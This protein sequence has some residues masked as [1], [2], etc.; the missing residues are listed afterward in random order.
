MSLI[1]PRVGT[2]VKTESVVIHVETVVIILFH[3]AIG[4]IFVKGEG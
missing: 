2:T 1:V 3:M 4:E